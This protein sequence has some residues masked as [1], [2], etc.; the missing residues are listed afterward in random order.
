MPGEP[1]IV[2]VGSANV[3]HVVRMP[4]IPAAGET[5]LARRLSLHE[6]GKGANQAVAASRA[7]GSV[8]FIGALGRDVDGDRLLSALADAGVTTSCMRV[9]EEPTGM[10][11]IY[12]DDAGRNSIAVLPGANG[13]LSAE[14]VEVSMRKYP[15]ARTLLVQLEIPMAA[16]TAAIRLGAE[17]GLRVIL[18]PAPAA[19]LPREL[20]E[21]VNVLTPNESEGELLAEL[22]GASGGAAD[23][24]RRLL[25]TGPGAVV[26]T[27]GDAGACVGTGA[28]PPVHVSAF[29]A[30]PVDTTAAGDVFNGTL[31]VAL[32]EGTELVQ[33]VRFA[34]AA[35]ALSVAR[36]GA[37]RSA[38]LRAEI[39]SLL[40]RV[41]DSASSRGGARDA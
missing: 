30:V 10:A 8:A 4:R 20:L 38:P 25:E 11:L 7:G 19:T 5:V 32:T 1:E 26:L 36:E 16:V 12:V 29:P 41:R 18:N 24:V 3:D 37:Q 15:A 17:R 6:G 33:G 14:H 9:E 35:A 13:R 21:R 31:A 2:V 34:S 23:Q 28:G 22:P 27:L 40:E 39:E